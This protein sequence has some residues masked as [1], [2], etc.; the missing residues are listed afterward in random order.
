[1]VTPSIQLSGQQPHRSAVR[2]QAAP[3][4]DTAAI[5]LVITRLQPHATCESPRHPG[6]EPA[7]KGMPSDTHE[8]AQR[9]RS[10]EEYPEGEQVATAEGE[11]VATA[12]GEEVATAGAGAGHTASPSRHRRQPEE[13]SHAIATGTMVQAIAR[14]TSQEAAGAFRPVHHHGPHRR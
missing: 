1:M 14:G 6:P 8:V 9:Q 11:E 12:Q 2:Q 13:V 10:I 3:A 4:T 7:E 5:S